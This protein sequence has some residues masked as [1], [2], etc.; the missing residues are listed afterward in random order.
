[1][2][3]EDFLNSVNENKMYN[4]LPYDKGIDI[5]KTDGKDIVKFLNTPQELCRFCNE[6]RPTFEWGISEKKQEEWIKD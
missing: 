5:H 4:D 2:L 3:Q 1:M 6:D